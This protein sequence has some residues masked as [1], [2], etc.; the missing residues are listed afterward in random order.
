MSPDTAETC[1]AHLPA[2]AGQYETLRAALLGEALP[3]EAR[4]GLALFLQRGMWAWARALSAP[5]ARAERI[6]AAALAS[7]APNERKAVIYLLAA[8]AMNT[9]DRRAR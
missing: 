1:S 6:P 4:S 8:L 2:V 7:T 3:P 9:R 5:R